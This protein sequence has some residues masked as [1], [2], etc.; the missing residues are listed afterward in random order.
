MVGGW[1]FA[2]YPTGGAYSVPPD[3]IAGL[4]GPNSKALLPMGR[5]GKLEKGRAGKGRCHRQNDLCP[6]APKTLT[7][8]LKRISGCPPYVRHTCIVHMFPVLFKWSQV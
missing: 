2:P 5:E 4:K 3:P 8:L 7:P 1:G 6:R